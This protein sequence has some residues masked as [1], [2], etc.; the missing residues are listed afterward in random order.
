[1]QRDGIVIGS[2]LAG[3]TAALEAV[4]QGKRVTLF[5]MAGPQSLGG[6]ALRSLGGCRFSGRS[7]GRHV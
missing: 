6:Q 5:G 7:A 4:L 2:G 1:M 3:M